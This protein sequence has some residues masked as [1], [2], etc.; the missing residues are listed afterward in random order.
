MLRQ[1][2]PDEAGFVRALWTAPQNALWLDPP[3]E[4]QIEDALDAGHLLVWDTGTP[5]GWL[6]AT[7]SSSPSS[8]SR[9]PTMKSPIG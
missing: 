4:G 6:S 2:R 3:E 5:S 9:S 7:T 1:A 8:T